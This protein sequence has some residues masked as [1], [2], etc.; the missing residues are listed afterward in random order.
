MDF[1]IAFYKSFT[2]KT[3]TQL[4]SHGTGN[5]IIDWNVQMT[6]HI[7]F[8]EKNLGKWR[9]TKM[10]RYDVDKLVGWFEIWQM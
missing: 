7:F 1:Q 3:N 5:S 9:Y 6:L 10:S 4:K 2:S 8:L